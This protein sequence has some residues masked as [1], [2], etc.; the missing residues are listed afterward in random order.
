MKKIILLR[1]ADASF[2]AKDDIS[3]NLSSLGREQLENITQNFK[4]IDR[5]GST[6]TRVSTANRTQQ[7]LE[8]IKSQLTKEDI[9]LD[10]RIYE[11]HRS[12]LLA[13]LQET[14]EAYNNLVIIGHNP[15][16]TDLIQYLTFENH[17]CETASIHVLTCP[18]NTWKD[19]DAHQEFNV[20]LY[21]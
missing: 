3:R 13:I 8:A 12:T 19:I 17:F 5:E 6:L 16:L 10:S 21:V 18:A 7:T 2:S 14:S 11:C 4:W 1:H 15:G 9:V 20:S